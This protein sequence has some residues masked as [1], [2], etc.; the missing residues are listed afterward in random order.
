MLLKI[1]KRRKK[2]ILPLKNFYEKR[3]TVL[4]MRDARGIGDILMHRMLFEDFKKLNAEM[5]LVVAVFKEYFPL[6]QNHPF[7]DEVV[8]SEEVDKKDFIITYDTSTC[9]EWKES[10]NREKNTLSRP[11]IWA[12]H[13]G[14]KLTNHDMHLPFISEEE[15]RE[16]KEIL[17]KVMKKKNTVL[18]CPIAHESLR[19]L[20]LEIS[21]QTIYFLQSKGLN[22]VTSFH[23]KSRFFDSLGVPV[24][25]NLKLT[26]WLSLMHAVDYVVSVD[27]SAFHYAGGI[28]KPLMGIFTH[29]D[30]KTR[31]KHYDFVL[32]QKHRDNGDWPCGPCYNFLMCSHP[33]CKDPRSLELRPCL[34][35]LTIGEIQQGIEKMLLKWPLKSK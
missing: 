3:N 12:E 13:C 26:Q 4:I 24:I 29:V 9:S 35:E 27:T 18:F 10:F 5:H 19:S 8:D 17:R 11:E 30:G 33:K 16:G 1:K 32:V 21:K 7:I 20:P 2:E 34:T 22:V 6:L 23:K 31:G 25:Y 15:I 14:I 28:K